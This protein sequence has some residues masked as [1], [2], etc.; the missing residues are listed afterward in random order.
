MEFDYV[1]AGGG[2]A[3]CVLAARLTEDPSVSVCLIEAG[4]EGRNLMVR[5]PVGFGLLTRG[6]FRNLYWPFQTVPQPGLGGRSGF[7]PRGKGLGGSSAINAMLYI[8]GHRND[9][10]GWAAAG[11]T[12]WGYDDVLPFFRKAE[13]NSRG[14]DTF[15][16]GDGPLSVTDQSSPRPIAKAFVEA[17]AEHQIR[18]NADFNGET[19]EGAGYFQVTQFFDGPHKGERCSVAAAYLHPAMQRR[20]LAV[21]TGAQVTGVDFKGSTASGLSYRRAGQIET[22]SARREVILCGGAFG[23]PQ[24]LMLSGIG[25]GAELARHGI[26][27]RHDAPAVGRNL[28]DHLDFTVLWKS[29][30]PDMIGIG[31]RGTL[32]LMRAISEWRKQG[33]GMLTS[34]YAEGAA[35]V[36]SAPDVER[37]DLQLH[38]VVAVVDDHG[39]RL[40]MG[41]GFSCH[42]CVLRP[43]SRGSVSLE[44]ADPL[45]PPR[46]DPQFLADERDAALLLKGAKLMRRLMQA[47]ALQPY[48]K[49][50]L[51][52]AG[53]VSDDELMRHI[54]A[55]ADTIYHPVGTAR[56]GSDEGSVVD[57]Q[58]RVRGVE[59]LRVVD[60]SVM[61]TL[62]GG[63]TN[64]PTIMIAEKAA[65]MIRAG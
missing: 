34:P 60:A 49:K 3:G 40:H 1:I 57:P 50:E 51:Y 43:F 62:V 19:Q 23:T 9:Y 18:F 38:F 63:N 56:M 15:H 48:R 21:I 11:C 4:G 53:E 29:R 2:S 14:D 64:A 22:V 35:F 6:P 45:A 13:R 32:K 65:A 36:R 30:D 20:N 27:V 17:C 61:P 10:D 41:Y 46:I 24:M 39:R 37:P 52:L 42:V 16:G 58:L 59:R 26:A 47:S 8:R 55:R 54:R 12:G 25:P 28:Q 33:T 31:G 5:L 7:Q 44:N